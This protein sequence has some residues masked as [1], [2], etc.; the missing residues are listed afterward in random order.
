MEIILCIVVQVSMYL[1]SH[2]IYAD[3]FNIKFFV[4]LL[5]NWIFITLIN[6]EREKTLT[7]RYFAGSL[8]C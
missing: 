2:F 6:W 3:V 5:T 7:V 4:V 8:F 1:I